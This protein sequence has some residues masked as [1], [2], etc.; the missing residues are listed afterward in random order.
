MSKQTKTVQ[1]DTMEARVKARLDAEAEVAL[2]DAEQASVA[3]TKAKDTLDKANGK[4][5]AAVEKVMEGMGK[6]ATQAQMDAPAKAVAEVAKAT[7]ALVRAKEAYVAACD[8][9]GVLTSDKE[10]ARRIK[11]AEKMGEQAEPMTG[12]EA[13]KI[14]L[15]RAG[16][17][18]HYTDIT[19]QALESGVLKLEGKTPDAT[20]SAYLAKAAKK[21]DTFVRVA[22]GTFDLADRIARK[23]A[24]KKQTA[25]A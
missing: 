5:T 25:K 19:R 6:A 9:A 7:R 8:K 22:P 1:A 16:K 21:G 17:P 24:A 13:A 12:K 20:M 2:R 10:L 18:M 3:F 15:L 11:V 14:V 23:K 4:L